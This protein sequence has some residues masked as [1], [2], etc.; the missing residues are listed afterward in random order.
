MLETTDGSSLPM[1]TCS[2]GQR[3]FTPLMLGLYKLIPASAKAK[4]ENVNTVI[5]EEP[6]MGLHPRAITSFM[7][8]V[9]ELLYRGYSVVL[10]THSPAVLE[11]A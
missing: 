5:I 9:M 4:D 2:P 1:P 7:F 11:I 3:E 6:E 8:V 10:S